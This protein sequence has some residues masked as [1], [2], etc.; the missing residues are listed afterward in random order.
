MDTD[1]MP[2]PPRERST[3]LSG[4]H[5]PREG[6][7]KDPSTQGKF[8]GGNHTPSRWQDGGA[9]PPA[10]GR[11]WN[12]GRGRPD[13]NRPPPPGI[14]LVVWSAQCFGGENPA[15]PPQMT[16]G[17]R[18]PVVRGPGP[19]P[20]R[21]GPLRSAGQSGPLPLAAGTV[22]GMGATL[23]HPRG[24]T[25]G[26]HRLTAGG[27]ATPTAHQVHYAYAVCVM[28]IAHQTSCCACM[29]MHVSL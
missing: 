11:G 13:H 20:P 18:G 9:A 27:G 15:A 2:P 19:Q 23:G 3:T 16:A 6:R 8:G 25:A 28:M 5:T 21:K 10:A 24:G 12:D 1:P 26:G 17:A 7:W 14:P 4:D 22:V 29:R